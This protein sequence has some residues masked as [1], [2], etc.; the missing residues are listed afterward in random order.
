MRKNR[1]LFR[2]ITISCIDYEISKLLRYGTG[3]Y[4]EFGQRES[5]RSQTYSLISSQRHFTNWMKATQWTNYETKKR[6]TQ[7][8][9]WSEED[10]ILIR[11]GE[12]G[13][14]T[15]T[16]SII[17]YTKST[18]C[19]N[20]RKTWKMPSKIIFQSPTN[21][22]DYLFVAYLFKYCGFEKKNLT[23]FTFFM[24]AKLSMQMFVKNASIFLNGSIKGASFS[25]HQ[26]L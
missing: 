25:S 3:N 14:E 8:A 5:H 26:I 16:L 9:I 23:L 11:G 22:G 18:A 17:Q 7:Q 21:Y 10:S 4:I 20:V 19:I 12:L 6:R 1:L 2:L 24:R 13:V 15:I